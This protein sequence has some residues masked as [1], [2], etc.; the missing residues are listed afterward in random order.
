MPYML[1]YNLEELQTLERGMSTVLPYVLGVASHGCS[2]LPS[3]VRGTCSS[4]SIRV[5]TQVRVSESL[6]KSQYPSHCSSH[7]VRDSIRVTAPGHC[8]DM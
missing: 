5:T 2:S 8:S 4:D 1:G 6:L 3:A 7:S